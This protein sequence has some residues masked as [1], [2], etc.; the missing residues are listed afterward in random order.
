MKSV[1]DEPL[2]T[3]QE[4]AAK[5]QMS[6][7]SVQRRIE[8]RELGCYRDG[9]MTLV[10]DSQLRAYLSRHSI[11][12]EVSPLPRPRRPYGRSVDPLE[13]RRGSLEPL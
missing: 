4:V 9:A 12:P 7:R 6:R 3:L 8:N 13:P 11:E 2:Y 10:S 1:M 5:L